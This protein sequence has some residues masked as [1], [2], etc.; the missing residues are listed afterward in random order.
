MTMTQ[1]IPTALA[2]AGILAGPPALS[3]AAPQATAAATAQDRDDT[4]KDRIAFRLDTSE[5]V[6]K[7][8]VKVKVDGGVATLS[9]DVATAAQKAEAEKLAKVDGI[10]R[11]QNE[12][13]IDPDEDRSLG[14]RMKAGMS[15]TGEKISDAWI[16]TKVNWFFVGEDTLKGSRI[17][18]DTKNNVVTLSGTVTSQAGRTRAVALAKQTEGV[19][20]VVDRLTVTSV[21]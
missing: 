21:R 18:V 17:D 13:A 16:T 11:V 15:K 1:H 3:G 2:L 20:D 8:D 6:R 12:I 14:E 5:T 7:Y 4:L 10:A 9:G 19:K